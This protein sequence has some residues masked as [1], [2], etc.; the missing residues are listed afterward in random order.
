MTARHISSEG[1]NRQKGSVFQACIC[2]ALHPILEVEHQHLYYPWTSMY[3]RG[4]LYF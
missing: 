4:K 2:F 3:L 1:M